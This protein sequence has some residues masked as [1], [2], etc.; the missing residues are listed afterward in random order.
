MGKRVLITG[1]SGFTGYYV[2]AEFNNLGWEVWGLGQHKSTRASSTNYI[3]ADLADS[4]LLTKV[5]ANAKP[6]VIIHLAAVAFVE[7]SDSRAFYEV[8]LL[9]TRNLLTAIDSSGHLPAS[10]I[11]ASSANVYGNTTGGSLSETTPM[12][13][14]NDYAV[15]KCASEYVAALWRDRLPIT[16]TRPFNYTGVGQS[17][18]FLVPKIVQHFRAGAKV[19]ELGNLDVERDFSDV[20]DVA[21]MYRCLAEENP[22]GITV[23][24]CSGRTQSL[25]NILITAGNIMGR[26]LEVKVNQRLVRLNEVETLSGDP[27]RLN[28]LIGNINLRTFET[29]LRWMLKSCSQSGTGPEP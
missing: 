14:A 21:T 25:R 22:V 24:L 28:N 17:Q 5:I 4:H 29:T 10:V 9:G 18:N 13:P 16:I 1:I 19:I 3:C 27:T 7:H 2:A 12:N 15:S 8:N 23:N 6:D 20:R 11:I 26:E